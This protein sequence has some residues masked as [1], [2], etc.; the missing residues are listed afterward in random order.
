MLSKTCCCCWIDILLL[1]QLRI[2]TVRQCNMAVNL[3]I[4]TAMIYV[5]VSM[6]SI[7]MLSL[8]YGRLVMY[9]IPT[10]L[11]YLSYEEVKSVQLLV[12]P[13][14]L[15]NLVGN[16]ERTSRQ[17]AHLKR[18]ELIGIS[19]FYVSWNVDRHHLERNATDFR[20][21]RQLTVSRGALHSFQDKKRS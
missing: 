9:C 20:R 4:I 3:M 17:L 16:L 14:T 5:Q 19:T 11:L 1:F 8:Y 10:L 13:M 2:S 12:N 7:R 15:A 21:I 6:Q 18:T